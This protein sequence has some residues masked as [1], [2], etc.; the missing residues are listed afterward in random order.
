MKRALRSLPRRASLA[1][2]LPGRGSRAA[3]ASAPAVQLAASAAR[4]PYTGALFRHAGGARSFAATNATAEEKAK[5]SAAAVI[6]LFSRQGS[7]DYVGEPVSQAEHALQAADLARRAGFGDQEILAALLHDVGHMIGLEMGDKVKRMDDC[8]IVDHEGLGGNWLRS[9][10]F[11]DRIAKLV[12][13]HVDAKRYL[14]CAQPGYHDK[15]SDASRTTLGF[16]G[17]P[18]TRDQADAFEKDELFKVIIAMRHWDEAAKV[19]DKV[20]PTL[21]SYRPMME[22]HVLA[23]L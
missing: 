20:V 3:A 23:Q 5:Q 1:A 12:T 18:M 13:R 8:G 21:E 6:S 16:Q 7:G 22:R 4:W 15:L 19:K 2:A 11:S 14:C 9:F 17:G 10:G